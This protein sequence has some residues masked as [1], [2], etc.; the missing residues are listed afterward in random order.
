MPLAA[1]NKKKFV[2]FLDKSLKHDTLFISQGAKMKT[3]TITKLVLTGCLKGLT[4]QESYPSS[5]KD[6]RTVGN[7]YKS[8]THKYKLLSI[9][10]C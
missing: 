5:R 6:I 2:F 3:V 1:D 4:L 7:V 8:Y 10:Y 9:Q